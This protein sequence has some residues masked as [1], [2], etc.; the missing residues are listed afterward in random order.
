MPFRQRP[1]PQEDFS[2]ERIRL[3]GVRISVSFWGSACEHVVNGP[4]RVFFLDKTTARMAVRMSCLEAERSKTW[5]LLDFS[6]LHERKREHK[7]LVHRHWIMSSVILE[8]LVR[9]RRDSS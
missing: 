1:Q 7:T 9:R 2:F 6:I 8:T 3:F 5:R 4:S